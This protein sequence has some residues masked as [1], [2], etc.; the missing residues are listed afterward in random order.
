MSAPFF[1]PNPQPLYKRMYTTGNFFGREASTQ[2][3]SQ[4]S[5]REQSTQRFGSVKSLKNMFYHQSS[6]NDL[7]A[8]SLPSLTLNIFD[9]TNEKLI[10][11]GTE[12]F[13]NQ[14]NAIRNK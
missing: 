5:K 6:S 13:Q 8:M 9:S 1:R 10:F 14:G 2:N 12:S 11:E 3:R 4:R 7:Q